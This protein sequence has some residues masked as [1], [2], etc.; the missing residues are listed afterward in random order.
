MEEKPGLSIADYSVFGVILALCA[1]IGIYFGC[2]GTKQRSQNEYLL[3]NRRMHALPVAASIMASTTSAIAILG[4]T[5]EVYMFTSLFFWIAGGFLILLPVA[6]H[7]YLSVFYNLKITSIYEYLEMRFSRPVRLVATAIYVIYKLLYLA[8]VIYAPSLALSAVTD[9][10]IWVA[11]V[12]VGLVC[13]F[14]TTMGGMK[15]V[16]WTDVIQMI[17]MF[18]GVLAVIIKGVVLLGGFEN[19]WRIADRGGRIQY[20]NFDFDP[21]TRN[22]VWSLTFGFALTLVPLS[23]V[24]QQVAQR[25]NSCRSAGQGLRAIYI[26]LAFT[27]V[28]V[29]FTVLP[30]V[31]IYAVYAECDPIRDKRIQK[32]DQLMAY[33]AVDHLRG[34]PGVPGLFIAAIFSAA[35]STLSSGLNSLAAVTL[36]DF[37][38]PCRCF[39]KI[40]DKTATIILKILSAVFGILALLCVYLVSQIGTLVQVSLTLSGVLLGPVFGTFT[41]G[42]FFPWANSKGAMIGLLAGIGIGAVI[43]TG[44]FLYNPRPLPLSTSIAG[45]PVE[46]ITLTNFTNIAMTT[47]TSTEA[48]TDYMTDT[49]TANV[50]TPISSNDGPTGFIWFLSMSYLWYSGLEIATTL[51][52]G[53]LFSFITGHTKAKDVNPK[54]LSPLYRKCCTCLPSWCCPPFPSVTQNGVNEYELKSNGWDETDE[55]YMDDKASK[56]SEDK[57]APMTQE[58]ADDDIAQEYTRLPDT[59]RDNVSQNISIDDMEKW[60]DIQ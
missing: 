8:L 44:K 53:I 35:L 47:F 41:L 56:H 54:L 12:T 39:K 49:N 17:L 11:T 23:G 29:F 50:S 31:I 16:I 38:K 42:L 18:V 2:S 34:V 28:Y 6:G 21:T 58:N 48:P 19:V 27:V 3:A 43:G 46:N 14:Y 9:L 7:L 15:A 5:A 26:S 52:F 60:D 33:F 51:V 30:G 40:S 13:T 10:N 59:K 24:S 57:T 22:T 32:P 1:V 37:L 45:C 20:L 55:E 36:E 4:S 25:F